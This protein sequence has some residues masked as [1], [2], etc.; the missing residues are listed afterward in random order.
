MNKRQIKKKFDYE[1]QCKAICG[2]VCSYSECR[3][4]LRSYHEDLIKKDR[5]YNLYK[6]KY[7]SE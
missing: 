6:L 7:E 1:W 2:R 5:V 4:F 3:K